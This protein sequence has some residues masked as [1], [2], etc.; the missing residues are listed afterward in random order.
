MM[1]SPDPTPLG[2]QG[3]VLYAVKLAPV[4]ALCRPGVWFNEIKWSPFKIS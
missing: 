4:S 1:G 3:A 2:R